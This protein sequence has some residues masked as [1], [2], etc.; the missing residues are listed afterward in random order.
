MNSFPSTTIFNWNFDDGNSS[1]AITPSHKY[2]NSGSYLV[3]LTSTDTFG[4]IH[5]SSKTIQINA[6]S[7][8]ANAGMNDTICSLSYNLNANA[9]SGTWSS[10]NP[11]IFNMP[12]SSSSLVTVSNSGSYDL[13]WT[14]NNINSCILVDTVDVIFSE[15]DI[16]LN[17]T[18]PNCV[19]GNDGQVLAAGQGGIAPYIYQ[20]G[21]NAN[22]QTSNL[23]T[24]LGAGNY[25][26]TITDSFGC[27][28]DSSITLTN[29]QQLNFT[30]VIS[31]SECDIP[32]GSIT[33]NNISGGTGPYYYDWGNGPTQVNSTQNLPSG[34]HIL[35]IQDANGCDTTLTVFVPENSFNANIDSYTDVS[36]FG[37]NNG[38]ATAVGPN[39]TLTYN[40]QWDLLTGAQTFQTAVNLGP[41]TYN[42]VVSSLSGLCS[43]TIAI[44]ISEPPVMYFEQNTNNI[45]ACTGELINLYSKVNG[46]TG[47]Y[48]YIWNNNLGAGNNHSIIAS[49][50]TDYVVVASDINGCTSSDT[51]TVN[52][53]ESPIASFSIYNKTNC[54]NSTYSFINTSAPQSVSAVWNFG[55]NTLAT[56]NS[57]FHSFSSSGNFSIK[58]IVTN[59]N[60]CKDEMVNDNTVNIFPKPSADFSMNPNEITTFNTEVDFIDQSIG[61][62]SEWNWN[63]NKVD[64][65]H[66]ENPSYTFPK[67]PDNYFVSLEVLNEYGC[68][69]SISKVLTIN[70]HVNIFAPN[71]FTPDKNNFNQ[72]W[73]IYLTGIDPYYIEVLIFNRWGELIWES[74]DINIPWDGKYNG[75][76]VNDGTYTWTVK[77]KETSSSKVHNF[78]G[79]VTVLR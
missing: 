61:L 18:N 64:V 54:I 11:V 12:N 15:P 72:N 32:N 2:N 10:P 28:L 14:S 25:S 58:L 43:D 39:Q 40:Y 6:N 41:G 76:N 77:A 73:N 56:G 55:D 1:S 24:N 52:T 74:H 21:I 46:G 49:Q 69:D 8:G 37:L 79:F 67:I 66:T 26:I 4:C 47:P 59:S 22:N 23:A 27:N 7:F 42:A 48:N 30:T 35:L 5:T 45:E 65:S 44:T 60:G 19:N 31:P 63:F 9:G 57:V 13:I 16:I 70:D 3:Q 78:T 50:Q 62:I 38:T 33:I 17:M 75:K 53:L 34:T 71:I 36:C 20:W 29:P 68:R 51:V